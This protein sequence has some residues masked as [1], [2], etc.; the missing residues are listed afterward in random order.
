MV[1]EFNSLF[2]L[3]PYGR[4]LVRNALFG[5]REFPLAAPG[6]LKFQRKSKS[7]ETLGV[8][9]FPYFNVIEGIQ[10]KPR[11]RS[12]DRNASPRETQDLRS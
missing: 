8:S 12:P 1:A 7:V 6:V 2:L 5:F 3:A 9:E 10:S 11:P 4:H